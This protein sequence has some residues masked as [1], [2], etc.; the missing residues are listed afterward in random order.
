MFHSV[1]D[2]MQKGWIFADN[3]ESPGTVLFWH[4]IGHAVITGEII[5]GDVDEDLRSFLLG[6]YGSGQGRLT[7]FAGNSDWDNKILSLIKKF[8]LDI[9]TGN[10]LKFQFN[11]SLF[12]PK[13]YPIPLGYTL[14][15]IDKTIFSEIK[16]PIAPSVSWHSPEAFLRHG[17]GY[18][19]MDGTNVA[20]NTFISSIGNKQIDIGIATDEKYRGKG[21]GTIA[22]AVMIS[23]ILDKGYEPVWITSTDNTG[24]MNIARKLGFEI[25]GSNPFYSVE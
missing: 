7:L 2:N 25:V 17:K 6:N 13:N 3:T 9:K 19:L 21:L 14:K 23:Y 10:M 18:C 4:Y 16:G 8:S 12:F 20:C 5:G 24:S 22:A 11:K 1:I 15:E